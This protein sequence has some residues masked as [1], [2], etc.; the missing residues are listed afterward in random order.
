MQ[1]SDSSQWRT[2]EV[3]RLLA[4]VESE[5]RYYQDL[6]AALPVAVA[7]VAED[8]SLL[9]VN[10]EFRVRFGLTGEDLSRV[11]VADLLPDPQLEL[12]LAQLFMGERPQSSIDITLGPRRMR[13][14]LQHTHGWQD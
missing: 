7:V 8:Q 12:V 6:F 5:R 3:A 2:S 9:T 10:R 14:V 13:V 1:R 4:L 11:R